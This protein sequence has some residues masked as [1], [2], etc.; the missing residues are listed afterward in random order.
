MISCTEFIAF[1]SEFFKHLEKKG[2]YDAVMQYWYC[3]SDDG[4]GD[5]TNPNSLAANCDLYGGF[6][7]AV[8]YWNHT[9]TE[10]ACDVMILV[11]KEKKFRF[12][13][14]RHCPSR[15]M[16]NDLKHIEPYHD[17]CEH[18]NVIYQR[19]LKNY[20]MEMIRDHSKISNAECRSIVC[21]KGKCP[22]IDWKNMTDE[23]IIEK[24]GNKDT[25]Q[26]FN[27][28]STD[29]KYFHRDFHVSGDLSLKYCGETYGDEEVVKFLT[30][31][32]KKFYAPIIAEIKEQGLIAIKQWLETLY[33]KEEASELLH[34]ELVDDKLIVTVDKSPVIEYMRSLNQEPSKYYVEQ[35]RTLYDVVAKECGFKFE[36]EYYNEDGATKFSFS[37]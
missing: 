31:F 37:K 20:D 32:T 13:H 22:D 34:T 15:G 19:V 24:Y 23:E 25:A 28:K 3:I 9:L 12:S 10:E 35:T 30:E 36:L 14:M 6:L 7:G 17:Y 33:A 29:N 16:L 4:V 11:D 26:I 27:L 2:G 8:A 1:Y 21:E 18:C 5:K